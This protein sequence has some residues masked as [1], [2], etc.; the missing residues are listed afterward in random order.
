[1]D[2]HVRLAWSCERRS[3]YRGVRR[4]P[5]LRACR[6]RCSRGKQPARASERSRVTVARPAGGLSQSAERWRRRYRGHAGRRSP[7][8]CRVRAGA[9]NGR[10]YERR[11]RTKNRPAC[12]ACRGGSPPQA[13]AHCCAVRPHVTACSWHSA[14][15]ALPVH[16]HDPD[17]AAGGAGGPGALHGDLLR[18][19]ARAG[20]QPA[21]DDHAEPAGHHRH[22]TS[23]TRT[24]RSATPAKSSSRAC[25]RTSAQ[26]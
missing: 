23:S 8:C 5:A 17:R 3:R 13:D 26:A 10:P 1:M 15:G 25:A 9:D 21:R 7:E 18:R 14:A 20:D 22:A 16:G 11:T 2:G 4:T 6:G 24:C 12:R 19:P